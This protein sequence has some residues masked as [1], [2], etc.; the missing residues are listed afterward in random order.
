MLKLLERFGAV[1]LK[2]MLPESLYLKMA[3]R[4]TPY[5]YR[6]ET[7]HRE[8]AWISFFVTNRC[9]SRCNTCNIWKKRPFVDIDIKLIEKI[10]NST[11][12]KN[13]RFSF[14]GG[15]FFLH[16][17]YRE[18][19][20]IFDE[21]PQQFFIVTNGILTDRIVSAAMDFRLKSVIVSLNGDRN[22]YVA[23]RGIDKFDEVLSTIIELKKIHVDVTISYNINRFNSKDD[24]LFVENLCKE[25]NLRLGAAF[26]GEPYP[27]GINGTGIGYIKYN[28]EYISTISSSNL[29]DKYHKLFFNLYNDW[30]DGK[31]T[32]PCK[33]IFRQLTI[34]ENGDVLLC[35][36]QDIV[37]GNLHE[38]ELTGVW[39]SEG[40]IVLQKEY[41]S[42]NRCWLECHRVFDLTINK[43][44]ETKN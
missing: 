24:F 20:A 22:E 17:Q 39:D 12:F 16:P 32:L 21:H 9:N 23:D 11:R 43:V 38:S 29:I 41:S 44:N 14:L 37:L 36:N 42:C 25:N 7:R 31:I 3:E 34:L 40:T 15:E 19:L 35:S 4:Y 1:I 18:I 8:L 33:S 27:F 26:Y 2:N 10:V 13:V 5:V 28:K 6:R 30:V